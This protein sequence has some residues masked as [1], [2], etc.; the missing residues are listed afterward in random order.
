M[1]TL[2]FIYRE[3]E[4]SYAKEAI[5]SNNLVVYYYFDNSGL[6][7][8]L[9]KLQIDFCKDGYVCFYIDCSKEKM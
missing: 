1:N 8:Y 7:Y 3:D 6:S 2:K 4:L 5:N 9:K